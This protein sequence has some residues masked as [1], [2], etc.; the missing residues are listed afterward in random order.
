MKRIIALLMSMLLLLCVGCKSSKGAAGKGGATASGDTIISKGDLGAG[1]EVKNLKNKELTIM[2]YSDGIEAY[3]KLNRPNSPYTAYQILYTWK[4]TYGVEIKGV[5]LTTTDLIAAYASD[6]MP[7]V[8]SVPVI[9]MDLAMDLSGLGLE[10]DPVFFHDTAKLYDWTGHS[11]RVLG[12][13][14]L[15]RKYIIFN[16]TRFVNE[17]VKTPLEWYQEGKWTLTQFRA[18]AKEMTNAA[19]DQYGL[20]GN[21]VNGQLCPYPL[22]TWDATGKLTLNTAN[23][24]YI[25]FMNELGNIWKVDKSYRTDNKLQNWREE[26][27]N[28][29]DAMLI[30]N[31]YEYSEICRKSKLKGGDDF[32]IAPMFTSDVTGETTAYYAT[33]YMAGCI[34]AKAKNVEGAIE[35]LR[36]VAYINRQMIETQGYFCSAEPYLTEDERAALEETLDAPICTRPMYSISENS[37]S[38]IKGA[39]NKSFGQSGISAQLDSVTP[40]LQQEVDEYNSKI[41]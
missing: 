15:Q 22:V 18:T 32:G 37:S 21:E 10:K 23:T 27:V 29:N 28:G 12:T 14:Q 8:I 40:Q 34:S 7:D 30:G 24:K 16:E 35:Y 4:E 41:K 33:S 17:G 36:L 39:E 5:D 9:N 20:T 6:N 31:E 26:F 13:K 38:I 1:L 3:A 19:N 11:D 2:G 25:T